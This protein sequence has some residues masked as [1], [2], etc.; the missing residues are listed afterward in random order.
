M[1]SDFAALTA[2]FTDRRKESPM[3]VILELVKQ[4]HE[5]QKELDKKLTAHMTNETT[6]LAEAITRLMSEAFPAGDPEGHRH[7]HELVIKRA[8]ESAKFWGEM[9]IAAGKW[10]G[11]GVLGFLVT[12]AWQ[13]FLKGPHA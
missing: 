7:H 6:E 11:L 3:P 10:I 1:T 9:R 4:I 2:E 13:T 5:S 8:E 12:A